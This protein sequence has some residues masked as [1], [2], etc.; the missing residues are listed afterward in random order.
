MYA[1][2]NYKDPN[3]GVLYERGLE[4]IATTADPRPDAIWFNNWHTGPVLSDPSLHGHWKGHRIH[5]YTGD[6]VET[7]NDNSLQIDNDVLN[8]DVV[9]AVVPAKAT[10]P[11]LYLAS[12]PVTSAGLRERSAPTTQEPNVTQ[13]Y[14][15]GATLDIACQAV[16]ET[17]DGSYVWD[18]LT[19]GNYV[20]DVNT[21][22][23][24]GL[25]FTAGIPKCDKADPVATMN[26][27]RGVTL[28]RHRTFS[29]TGQDLTTG[30]APVSGIATYDVRWRHSGPSTGFGTWHVVRNAP[31]KQLRLSLSSGHTYCVQ[32]RATD[33]S[34]NRSVWSSRV[35][36]ARPLDDRAL[37][38]ARGEWKRQTGSAYWL[39]TA[40]TTTSAGGRLVRH[41]VRAS[42][43]GVVATV[44]PACGSVRVKIGSHVVGTLDLGAATRRFRAV[45]VLPG[46]A[47]REG[48][49]RLVSRG[50]KVQVDGLVATR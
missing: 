22:T 48:T 6:H 3:T 12:P 37:G 50:G 35:C 15:Y 47:M 29:W 36:T 18:R 7:F 1:V 23:T 46:G 5:Q 39:S 19:N 11:Y 43:F 31:G 32:V 13:V 20:S 44:C 33:R 17:I 27:V 40:T 21:T 34:N 30:D 49:V 9:G 38:V 14:D 8:G 45:L 28:S 41:H 25:S 42:T 24:G 16:G 4:P 26:A 2:A 10:A